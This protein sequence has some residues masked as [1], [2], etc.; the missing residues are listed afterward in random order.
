MMRGCFAG[1]SKQKNQK[2]RWRTMGPLNSSKKK[3]CMHTCKGDGWM[4]NTPFFILLS[5]FRKV[6]KVCVPDFKNCCAVKSPTRN[7]NPPPK[8]KQ[9][10]RHLPA[11]V[12][13]LSIPDSTVWQYEILPSP[14]TTLLCKY[15]KLK[16]TFHS[17]DG[18]AQEST[19]DI[20]WSTPVWWSVAH[21]S[22]T[23]ELTGPQT[24]DY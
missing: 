22:H 17:R 21:S 15:E 24:T 8:K 13:T 4:I 3:N 2:W 23:P 18:N 6:W 5:S 12:W 9:K 20:I 10:N 14:D 11:S 16:N 19:V 7:K 1:V